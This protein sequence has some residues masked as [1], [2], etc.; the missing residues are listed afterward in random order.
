[1]VTR[2]WSSRRPSTHSSRKKNTGFVL[3]GVTKH[4]DA[5]HFDCTQC[6]SPKR[7]RRWM[8]VFLKQPN[9]TAQSTTH[10]PVAKFGLVDGIRICFLSQIS[11]FVDEFFVAPP[12]CRRCSGFPRRIR[13]YPYDVPVNCSEFPPYTFTPR[14]TR[15]AK[16][17]ASIVMTFT[18]ST[19]SGAMSRSSLF[20]A[21]R[22]RK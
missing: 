14:R 18:E 22:E 5:E 21:P 7:P 8:S 10:S 12:I 11:L 19:N 20:D 3:L 9:S 15:R 16:F 1:M 2:H 4:K 13:Q 6:N 17:S